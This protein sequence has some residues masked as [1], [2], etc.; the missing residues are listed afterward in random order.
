[1]HCLDLGSSMAQARRKGG[2]RALPPQA[3]LPLGLPLPPQDW[4]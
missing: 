2:E 3:P 4:I 1:M